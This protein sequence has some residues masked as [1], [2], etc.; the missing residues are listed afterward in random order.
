MN[1][2]TPVV[3]PAVAVV[4]IG[5]QGVTKRLGVVGHVNTGVG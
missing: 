3:F 1:Q 4:G 5:R 2:T